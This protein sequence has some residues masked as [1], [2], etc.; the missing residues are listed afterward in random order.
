MNQ[1]GIC[2]RAEHLLSRRT[3]LGGLVGGAAGLLG[4]PGGARTASG[5]GA[6]KRAKR[7][8]LLVHQGGL[9]QL[10]SW[11]PKP[12]SPFAGPCQLIS[13]S[14]PGIQVSE[15]LPHTSKQMHHLLLVRSL[16][17]NENNHGPGH[18]LMMSGRREGAA[19]VYPTLDCVANKFLT[20]DQHPVPGFVSVGCPG[21]AAFLGPRYAPVNLE[22]GKPPSNLELPGSVSAE[23]DRRRS[24]LM[25][26]FNGRFQ[27]KRGSADTAAYAY[28]FDQA[29]QLV[30]NKK[31]FD[32][33]DEPKGDSERYGTHEF[34]QKCLLARRLLEKGVTCVT[35]GHGGYDTHAENFNVHLDL[36]EQFDRPFAALIEDLAARGLL[37]ETLVVALGEFGRTPNI[38]HRFGRDHW[39]HTWS[40]AIAGGGFPAGAV[41][42]ATNAQGSEVA[43][44][45][46]EAAPLFHTF[47]KA[48]GIDATG[49]YIVEGDEVP[50]GDPAAAPIADLL[51]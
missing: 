14:V 8:L 18:Y 2:N 16:S 25:R 35:V 39:S 31:L 11:D 43:D 26:K 33:A 13:T 48:L 46:V 9:S 5:E 44:K 38:N 21:S 36:L 4:V 27:L 12:G 20:P 15:W 42:G 7:L 3:V 17:T 6:A 24:E 49:H 1:P 29:V 47:C 32:L 45:K 34:G 51:A 37:A 22:P 40:I 28:S 41:Y 50:I 23:S 30:Q 10:E 19:L